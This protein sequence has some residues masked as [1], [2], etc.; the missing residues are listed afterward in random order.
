LKETRATGIR[1]GDESPATIGGDRGGSNRVV[2][3]HAALNSA[4]CWIN[5]MQTAR[6]TRE[7]DQAIWTTSRSR[8]HRV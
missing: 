8:E 3:Q 1:Y 2:E 7:S 6:G 4:S 5:K